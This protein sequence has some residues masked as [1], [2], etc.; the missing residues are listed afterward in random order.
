MFIRNTSITCNIFESFL[1]ADE[2]IFKIINNLNYTKYQNHSTSFHSDDKELKELFIHLYKDWMV[3]FF[4]KI[5]KEKFKELQ[6]L[7]I[8]CQ[9]YPKKARHGVHVHHENNNYVSFIWYIDCSIN[10]SNTVFYNPGHPH[11]S[12]FETEIKP[13]KNKIVFFDAYIP[14]E[15][16]KNNDDKRCIISGNFKI[17]K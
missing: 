7:S 16:L 3:S 5:R 6:L 2:K 10:S 1:E 17:V 11:C 4:L 14:H 8:W 9:K 12:Y 13:E 15:V